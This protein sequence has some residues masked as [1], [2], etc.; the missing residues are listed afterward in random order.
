MGALL[1]A[2][3]EFIIDKPLYK[4]NPEDILMR[5]ERTFSLK[6]GEV[7]EIETLRYVLHNLVW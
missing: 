5:V 6:E 3:K 4:L 1:A 7:E 2:T